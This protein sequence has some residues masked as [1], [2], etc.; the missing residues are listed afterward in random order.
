[1]TCGIARLPLVVVEVMRGMGMVR[2]TPALV[3]THSRSLH[4][5]RA[6]MRRHAALCCRMMSSAA[7]EIGRQNVH[8]SYT[9]KLIK[10]QDNQNLSFK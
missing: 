7:V 9:R 4:T 5:I 8:K 1:M 3:P 10:I 6:V 2:I